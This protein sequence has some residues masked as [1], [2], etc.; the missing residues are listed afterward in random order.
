MTINSII[1]LIPARSGSKRVINKNMRKIGGDSLIKRCVL[2]AKNAKNIK[3]TYIITD[4][5]TYEQEAIQFGARSPGL[6]PK[7]ISGDKSSDINWLKWS[8]N[9]LKK[10]ESNTNFTNPFVWPVAIAFPLALN[11]N[12]PIFTSYPASNASDSV[13]PKDPI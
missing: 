1:A 5:N 11:E 13:Y 2:Q 8:L 3:E 4:S 9:E 6:R 12:L 7:E 10:I